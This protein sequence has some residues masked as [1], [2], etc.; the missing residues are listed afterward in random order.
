MNIITEE[1]AKAD[2]IGWKSI[3]ACAEWHKEQ[4]GMAKDPV[5]KNRHFSIAAKLRR[6]A[7]SLMT[8]K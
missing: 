2:G 5:Q 7:H 1:K 6:V 3:F 8:G 4:A